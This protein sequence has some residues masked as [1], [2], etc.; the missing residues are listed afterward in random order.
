VRVTAALLGHAEAA[1]RELL[2]FAAPADQVLSQYFRRH[3]N[4]GQK[5]RAFVAEA[6][7][8]GLM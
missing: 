1:L 8:S 5:D 2:R 4:L 3:R 7:S 6:R